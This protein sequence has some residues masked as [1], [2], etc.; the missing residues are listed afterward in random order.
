M[1]VTRDSSAS[2][3]AWPPGAALAHPGPHADDGGDGGELRG[4]SP[5]AP[6][7]VRP[8]LAIL[9][10]LTAAGYL[11]DLSASGYA[12]SFYAAAVQ[13]GTRSW[14][15]TFFGSLDSS[16]FITVDKP[17]A[18]LWVMDAFGRV[19]GFNSWSMLV[20]EALAGV[21]SVALLYATVKRWFGAPAGLVSAAALAAT[22][23]AALMFRFNNPDALLTLLLVAGAYTLV[24]AVDAGSTRWLVATGTLLGF[25]FLAKMLQGFMVIPAFAL[26]YLLAAPGALR[27]RVAQLL[28]GGVAI[29]VSAGWWVAAVA[30]WPAGSRP[31]IDGSPTNSIVN[32]I[33]GYNGFGRLSGS[34]GGAGGNGGGF[35]GATGVFRLFNT[36]MGGQASWLLP[37]ALLTLVA[38]LAWRGRAPRADQTRAGLLLWGT[39]LLV[40]AAVFS[41][42][43]GVIHTY[44]TV[45]LAPAIAALF[46]I[47][48]SLVWQARHRLAARLLG[49]AALAGTAVWA[50]VLLD[51]SP[52]Y[53]PWLRSAI[54]VAGVAAGAALISAPYMGRLASRAMSV[55]VGVGLVASLAAPAAYAATTI[56]TPHTG[57]V[58]SA[59][60][61]TAG[62]GFAGGGFAGGG[63]AGRPPS[64]GRPA[65]GSRSSG[66]PG[67]AGAPLG[68]LGGAQG[69]TPP[70]DFQRGGAGALNTGGGAGPGVGGSST[71]SSALTA[72]LRSGASSYRWAAATLGSQSAA[73]LELASGEPVMAIGGFSG[74]GGNLSL[75]T[76]QSYVAKHQIHY[77]VASGGGPRGGGSSGAISTWVAAHYKTTTIAGQTV[78]DLTSAK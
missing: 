2:V 35:S 51:R 46:G 40:T 7:W 38:G 70:V 69:A 17:P 56:L 48:V 26:V 54:L 6:R 58:P 75:T 55:A 60:P 18:A 62:G 1:T 59:G 28:L 47:G 63:F 3:A 21:G 22:P 8:A 27:R 64:G 32:L 49:A 72:A 5:G 52:T 78:Y 31:M 74:E 57:S 45:A 30:L 13:A 12:N 14:K 36:L 44:Y 33:F 20:P 29:V 16:N 77:F 68:I 65:G 53:H 67:G 66:G 43:K 34:G 10:V 61:A 11:W 71:V 39:W 24:R 4:A 23:V 19:F 15:A 37:A 50:A 42:G 25:A 41:F 73:T 76:F 9:L